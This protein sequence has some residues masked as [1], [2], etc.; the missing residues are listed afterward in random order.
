[1]DGEGGL[2]LTA[3]RLAMQTR[4]IS[5]KEWI[6]AEELDEIRIRDTTEV[7]GEGE[8]NS[9]VQIEVIEATTL[10]RIYCGNREENQPRIEFEDFNELSEEQR[11]LVEEIKT[12][13]ERLPNLR[14]KLPNIR[15]IDKKK[16]MT[17]VKKIND[18]MEHIPIGNI[19]ELND[20]FY[21]SAAIVT[22]KLAKNWKKKEEPPWRRR[23]KW[24]VQE[25]QQDISRVTEA[26]NRNYNDRQRRKMERRYNI[27]R[28]GY[29]Q[30]IEELKQRLIAMAAK[31]KRYD[32]RVKQYQQNRLFD[33]NQKAFYKE[34][35]NESHLMYNKDFPRKMSK[36]L[37]SCVPDFQ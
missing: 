36:S 17:E 34:I 16:I 10:N 29:Q 33:N 18:I 12:K 25:L 26:R 7:D 14:E 19:T 22:E 24:K 32:D 4:T 23:I 35:Q 11:K 3:E 9:R 27:K 28:K 6:T 20:T 15:H 2:E 13:R 21:V 1:M 37:W 30:V 5:K 8:G 31:L